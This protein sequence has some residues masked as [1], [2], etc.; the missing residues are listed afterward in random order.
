MGTRL[1]LSV[2]LFCV[3]RVGLRCRLPVVE[4]AA[5]G[6]PEEWLSAKVH[7]K[8]KNYDTN[9]GCESTRKATC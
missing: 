5:F 1:S 3:W 6:M 4:G 2:R 8:C 7:G 9:S